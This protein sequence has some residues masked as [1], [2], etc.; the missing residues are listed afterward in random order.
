MSEL[1]YSE[2][3]YLGNAKRV[4]ED[5]ETNPLKIRRWLDYSVDPMTIYKDKND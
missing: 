4:Y 2:F 5:F 3:R 1:H